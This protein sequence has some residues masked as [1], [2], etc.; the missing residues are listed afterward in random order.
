[1]KNELIES[2]KNNSVTHIIFADMTK[3][4]QECLRNHNA[5]CQW[6]MTNLSWQD[7]LAND[8]SFC[9]TDIY[10]IKPDY[11]PE[12]EY[13]DIQVVRCEQWLGVS[14]SGLPL[15]MGFILPHEFTHLH[16]LP[17]L[18]GFRGFWLITQHEPGIRIRLDK[19]IADELD[20]QKCIA[21]CIAEGE[22]VIARFAK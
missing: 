21:E 2:L 10:R 7:K 3:E 12:P 11:Q 4:E 5:Y 19:S 1:M 13:V 16:C 22:K 20:G 8:S 15:P 9:N 17:S 14:K 18:P 6:L